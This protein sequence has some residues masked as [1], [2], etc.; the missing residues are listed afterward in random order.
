MTDRNWP[1]SHYEGKIKII[2]KWEHPAR[3]YVSYTVS[4]DVQERHVSHWCNKNKKYFMNRR[5]RLKGINYIFDREMERYSVGI[6]RQWRSKFQ[7]LR[8]RINKVA[9][10]DSNAQTEVMWLDF[11]GY[12]K[13][14]YSVNGRK[15]E[16]ENLNATVCSEYIS[17]AGIGRSC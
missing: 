17:E 16:S 12:W 14:Q 9:V 1:R 10:T 5:K 15:S 11:R 6:L 2:G 8:Q 7:I 4:S 3:W 13:S